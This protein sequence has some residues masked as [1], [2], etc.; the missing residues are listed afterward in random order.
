LAHEASPPITSTRLAKRQ[1]IILP[2]DASLLQDDDAQEYFGQL[3]CQQAK[4]TDLPLEKESALHDDKVELTPVTKVPAS[5]TVVNEDVKQVVKAGTEVDHLRSLVREYCSLPLAERNASTQAEEIE[6]MTGY[7]LIPPSVKRQIAKQKSGVNLNWSG[8]PHD[9]DDND[10]E[11][12]MVTKHNDSVMAKRVLLL[13][14]GAM[15]DLMEKRKVEDTKHME[16]NTECRYQRSR[17]GKFRYYHLFT[18]QKISPAEYE[19]L[20]LATVKHS[21]A[22]MSK[23]IQDWLRE[24]EGMDT[25]STMTE[26]EI[27]K[28]CLKL[29][30]LV[31]SAQQVERGLDVASPTKDACQRLKTTKTEVGPSASESD[32][33]ESP[34]ESECVASPGKSDSPPRVVVEQVQDH[35]QA[36]DADTSSMEECD[37]SVSSLEDTSLDAENVA[38]PSSS[39][40]NHAAN[41]SAELVLPFPSRDEAS[42][43]PAIAAAEQRLWLE[44][45]EALE[46]YS[47]QVIAIREA[48]ASERNAS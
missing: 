25:D 19:E 44:I 3:Q 23:R 22:E 9:N 15:V 27:H 40:S 42:E 35:A 28:Q 24:N 32:M 31:E 20:Y 43:D 34:C 29:S 4:D 37:T 45:D 18:N 30:A 36:L 41:E 10:A 11:E 7:A 48:R 33:E 47:R 16:M 26:N 13:K 38:S 2:S 39:D 1:S 6:H 5:T 14:L 21:K 46:R 12:M 17:S 8:S